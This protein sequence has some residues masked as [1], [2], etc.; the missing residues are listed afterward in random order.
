MEV[1]GKPSPESTDGGDER[2]EPAVLR[3]TWLDGIASDLIDN[4]GSSWAEKE[5]SLHWQ[6]SSDVLLSHYD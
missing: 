4:P 5:A 6:D 3:P 1:R 2:E